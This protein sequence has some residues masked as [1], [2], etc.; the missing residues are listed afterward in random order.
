MSKVLIYLYSFFFQNSWFEDKKRLFTSWVSF[1]STRLWYAT[2]K[3]HRTSFAKKNIVKEIQ[4]RKKKKKQCSQRKKK[5]FFVWNSGCLHNKVFPWGSPEGQKKE[6]SHLPCQVQTC[7]TGA[8]T[9]WKEEKTY[10]QQVHVVKALLLTYSNPPRGARNN[11]RK[12][13]FC[14]NQVYKKISVLLLPWISVSKNVQLL[15]P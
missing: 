7:P 1:R 8:T 9:L 6:Q 12:F 4:R 10:L 11:W 14:L 5:H 13:V 15:I 3:N 2:S